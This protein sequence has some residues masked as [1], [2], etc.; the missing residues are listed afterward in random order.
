MS[1]KRDS[2]SSS[3]LVE[4]VR[5]SLSLLRDSELAAG[6]AA[7]MKTEMPFYGV[8]KPLRVPILREIKKN[9]A[10]RDL[11]EYE[12]CVLALWAQPHREEK[13]MAINYADSFQQFKVK[14]AIPLYER[15]IREGAWW[16]LVDPVSA[17][18]VGEAYLVERKSMK[19]LINKWSKD[20]DMWIRRCSLLAHLHHKDVT[21]EDQLFSLCLN[22]SSENE[23]FIR[24]AIGWALREYSKTAPKAVGKFLKSNRSQLSPLSNREGA[25]HLISKG[26]SF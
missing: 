15:L 24:K 12:A 5:N 10:P 21:D 13:Y 6:M 25:K 19:P 4:H 7:Y 14:D 8:Q 18:L 17:D 16:D 9:F 26:G 20:K 23:F 2:S 1:S 3:Q 11:S 22:L